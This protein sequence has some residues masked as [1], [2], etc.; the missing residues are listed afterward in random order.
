MV[1]LFWYALLSDKVEDFSDF[2]QKIRN[3][4]VAET[5]NECCI[6]HEMGRIKVLL[7]FLGR[8]WKEGCIILHLKQPGVDHERPKYVEESRAMAWKGRKET[9]LIDKQDDLTRKRKKFSYLHI[10]LTWG[11]PSSHSIAYPSD[12]PK[13]VNTVVLCVLLTIPACPYP[14]SVSQSSSM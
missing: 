4:G 7:R 5:S 8:C 6:L 9:F 14:S 13:A 1:S 10:L 11:C 12:S 3:A 2:Q